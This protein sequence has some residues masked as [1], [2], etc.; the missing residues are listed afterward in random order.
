LMPKDEGVL[1]D[2]NASSLFAL[3]V[4]SNM[5]SVWGLLRWSRDNH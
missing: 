2:L 1:N 4:E 3:T 5:L